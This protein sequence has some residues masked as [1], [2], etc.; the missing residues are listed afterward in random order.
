MTDE[1]LRDQFAR[2]EAQRIIETEKRVAMVVKRLTQVPCTFCG[3]TGRRQLSGST[4]LSLNLNSG[5][6]TCFWCKG[7][8]S[9]D[10][11]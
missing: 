1:E 9:V 5:N 7:T 4:G 8:G 11:K 2:D 10:A 3:A 6:V